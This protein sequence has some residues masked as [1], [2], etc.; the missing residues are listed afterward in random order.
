VRLDL[1]LAGYACY[2]L[3]DTRRAPRPDPP[4][5]EQTPTTTDFEAAFLVHP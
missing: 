2:A 4:K 5:A 1:A 3:M